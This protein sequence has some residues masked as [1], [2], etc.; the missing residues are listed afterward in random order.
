MKSPL[1]RRTV[2]RSLAGAAAWSAWPAWPQAAP[3]RNSYSLSVVPQFPASEIH[4]DWT[5]L[6]ERL[7]LHC[8]KLE[9]HDPAT[10]SPVTVTCDLPHDLTTV[11]SQLERNRPLRHGRPS[12]HR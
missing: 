6:L 7:A 8:Q 10:S 1:P 11:L 5:P 3:E 4:R 9:F 12:G 2:L